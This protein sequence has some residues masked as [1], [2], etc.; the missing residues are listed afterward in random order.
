LWLTSL[1]VCAAVVGLNIKVPSFTLVASSCNYAYQKV[2][3]QRDYYAACARRQVERCTEQLDSEYV[4]QKMTLLSAQ[5]SNQAFARSFDAIVANCSN[6][7]ATSKKAINAWSST[8]VQYTIPYYPTCIGTEK[9][10]VVS[11]LGDTTSSRTSVYAASLAYT[12]SSDSTIERLAEYSFALNTYNAAYLHNKTQQLQDLAQSVVLDVS[13]PHIQAIN[14]SFAPVGRIVDQIL[15]CASLAPSNST[16]TYPV[17]LTQ[18]YNIQKGISELMLVKLHK[19]MDEIV[20][21]FD[22][23][24]ADI[25]TAVDAANAFYDSVRG[26]KGIIAWVTANSGLGNLCGKS[27]PNFCSF[28]KVSLG[29]GCYFISSPPELFITVITHIFVLQESWMIYMGNLP[30]PPNLGAILGKHP[31]AGMM[32]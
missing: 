32:R 21:F 23:M 3:E 19:Y 16:C 18:V 14:V 11:S 4:H 15:A 9:Q 22:M 25:A 29:S 10:S 31:R 7:V 8:G 2:T 27:T 1:Q 17:T 20:A 24:S 30:Y 26:P 28:S 13:A 5:Q 6:A 12:Q